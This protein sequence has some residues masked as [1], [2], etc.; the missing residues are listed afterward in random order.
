MNGASLGGAS[1][2]A[3]EPPS[4]GPAPEPAPEDSPAGPVFGQASTHNPVHAGGASP[5][6]SYSGVSLAPAAAEALT[7]QV[8]T[9]LDPNGFDLSDGVASGDE[10]E[11]ATQMF[12]KRER[13]KAYEADA[14]AQKASICKNVA[15][16]FIVLVVIGALAGVYTVCC[17][18]KDDGGSDCAANMTVTRNTCKAKDRF[19]EED[20]I[21]CDGVLALEDS[22]ECTALHRDPASP[23]GPPGPVLCRWASHTECRVA[24]TPRAPAPAPPPDLSPPPPPASQRP[25]IAAESWDFVGGATSPD[26][27]GRY[28][29]ENSM[30]AWPGAR[31][32]SAIWSSGGSI[33]LLGGIGC[34]EVPDGLCGDTGWA[35]NGPEQTH[36]SF[37]ATPGKSP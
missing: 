4:F 28:A 10:R 14:T 15:L 31:S 9:T 26:S 8:D 3:Y 33:F 27:E 37:G 17:S 19:R 35:E 29:A 23:G 12:R 16:A 21:A 25:T 11:K 36:G 1:P 5:A 34:D 7:I 22:S 24:V 20:V 32:G 2:G 30:V 6:P 18:P 13:A